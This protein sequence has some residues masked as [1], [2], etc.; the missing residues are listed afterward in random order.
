MGACVT[1]ASVSHWTDLCSMNVES[2]FEVSNPVHT[3]ESSCRKSK[4]VIWSRNLQILD[5]DEINKRYD[6]KY[7]DQINIA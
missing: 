7:N 1:A 3:A 6:E 2:D 4:R 5:I